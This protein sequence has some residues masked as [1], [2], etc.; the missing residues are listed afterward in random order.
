[1]K[2]KEASPG[3]HEKWFVRSPYPR[4]TKRTNIWDF[5]NKL[6]TGDRFIISDTVEVHKV[7]GIAKTLSINLGQSMADNQALAE[8]RFDTYW[9]VQ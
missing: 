7:Q 9:Y 6:K 1:M 5:L 3:E 4:I 8:P 2:V